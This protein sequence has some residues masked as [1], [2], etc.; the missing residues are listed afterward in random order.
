[1]KPAGTAQHSTTQHSTAQNSTAHHSAQHSIGA[2]AD[3]STTRQ[4][5]QN[6]PNAG[7]AQPSMA[8]SG[9]TDLLMATERAHSN[10]TCQMQLQSLSLVTQ[11]QA[12]STVGASAA[13]VAC[14]AGNAGLMQATI[15]AYQCSC[16]CG[17]L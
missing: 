12:G 2:S 5:Q 14:C 9:R 8:V 10:R 1:M 16:I 11:Q 6:M 17:M 13:S 7:T 3:G 4:L 15:G